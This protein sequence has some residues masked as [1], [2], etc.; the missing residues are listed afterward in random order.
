MA[1]I[2]FNF[3]DNMDVRVNGDFSSQTMTIS[4]AAIGDAQVK[5]AANINA[6]KLE[7][8]YRITRDM[9]E[10]ATGPFVDEQQVAFVCYK[11]G[12]INAVKVGA[13]TPAVGGNEINFMLLKNGTGVLSSDI[14]LD[15]TDAARALVVG[16]ISTATIAADD[17]FELRALGNGAT[18]TAAAGVFYTIEYDENSV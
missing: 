4:D 8:K 7:H 18:G 6:D 3:P 5:S 1:N 13:I 15:S 10:G 16:T 11:A 9:N 12:T 17:V 2:L 14:N